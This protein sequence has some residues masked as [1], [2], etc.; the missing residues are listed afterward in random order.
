MENGKK[1]PRKVVTLYFR[2]IPAPL[3]DLFKGAC[4]RR[5]SDMQAEIL[6]FMEK[7]VEDPTILDKTK[8]PKPAKAKFSPTQLAYLNE[9][10]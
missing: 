6:K 5:G 8:K 7:F 10:M 2:K 9:R 1:P 3:R 4:Y